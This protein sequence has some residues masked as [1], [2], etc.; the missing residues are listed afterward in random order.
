MPFG[1][2]RGVAAWAEVTAAGLS[3]LA[4]VT[5]VKYSLSAD[6]LTWSSFAGGDFVQR[7]LAAPIDPADPATVTAWLSTLSSVESSLLTGL[8]HHIRRS[9][10]DGLT[11]ARQAV[12][13]LRISAVT[14]EIDLLQNQ[15]RATKPAPETVLANTMRL[16][17]LKKELNVLKAMLTEIPTA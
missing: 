9:A 17:T 1:P 6:G 11:T 2:V 7:I 5:T 16:I 4:P 10:T 12:A 8:Q 3:E 14:G 13:S 15:L